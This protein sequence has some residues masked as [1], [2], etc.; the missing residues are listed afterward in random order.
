MINSKRLI[1]LAVLTAFSGGI[2]SACNTVEGAGTD[3]KRGGAAI[4]RKAKE[5]KA[6][7]RAEEQREDRQGR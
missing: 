3:I 4:E 2:L 5:E 1:A 7:H 6:E